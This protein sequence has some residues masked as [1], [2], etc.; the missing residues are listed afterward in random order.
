MQSTIVVVSGALFS[1]EGKLLLLRRAGDAGA[2]EFPGGAL[3]FGETPELGLLR[4]F[5]E[6]TGIDISPD[7]PLGAWSELERVG[8]AER[9]IVHIDYT[10][11]AAGTITGVDLER[12]EFSAF[13]WMLQPEAQEK[14]PTPALKAL[15]ARAFA[16][17]ARSRKNG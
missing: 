14:L 15:A 9:Y 11:R 12:E 13:G 8:D 17:L 16:I 7:R 2:W 4:A 1:A 5:S 3:D 10:V 6:S